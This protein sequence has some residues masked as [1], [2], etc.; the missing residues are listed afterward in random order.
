MLRIAMLISGRAARYEVCLLPFLEAI[1]EKIHIIDVFM[2]INGEE[3][4]YYDIMRVKL[5][6]WLRGCY[7][8]KYE[9]PADYKHTHEFKGSTQFINGV[10]VHYHQMSMYY[11]D[12]NVFNLA[13]NYSLQN[14]IEYDYYMKYR[15]DIINTSLPILKQPTS[16]I[17][18]YSIVPISD[19]TSHG[20]YKYKIVSDAWTWGNK[21]TM[22]K[23]T[24]T[25][26]FVLD[27]LK[28]LNGNYYIGFEDCVTDN[29]YANKIPIEYVRHYHNL[30]IHRRIF[31][32]RWVKDTNGVAIE[33]EDRN[34]GGLKEYINIKDII[35]TSF[36]PAQIN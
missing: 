12:F 32:T 29:V 24:N 8:N 10:W 28:Q 5:K 2:S 13:V 4:A 20:L 9:L 34:M 31:D 11:N 35:D 36:I 21:E 26:F 14:N 18:L 15:S 33:T 25:Y 27:A 17:K 23:Y 22:R 16:E 30:D 7:I 19:F 1:D 3:C 6:K